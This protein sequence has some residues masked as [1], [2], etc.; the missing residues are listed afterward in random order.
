MSDGG[1]CTRHWSALRGQRVVLQQLVAKLKPGG[2]ESVGQEPNWRMRTK[3]FSK[4][5]RKTGARTLS[6]KGL[7]GVACC[8]GHNPSSIW[9]IS[10][11]TLGLIKKLGYG[12]SWA[13]AATLLS[14]ARRGI[15][16]YI[17]VVTA[18]SNAFSLNSPANPKKTSLFVPQNSPLRVDRSCQL[19]TR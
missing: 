9:R 15:L 8:R 12:R 13:S 6:P 19:G 10:G 11:L 5:W 14:A 16:S 3:P 1:I 18:A 4:T 2:T 17:A 7:S